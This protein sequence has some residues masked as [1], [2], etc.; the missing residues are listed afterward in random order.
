METTID[1]G[2]TVVF[3]RGSCLELIEIGEVL[4]WIGAACRASSFDDDYQY[5]TPSVLGSEANDVTTCRIS[6]KFANPES[7]WPEVESNT[8]CW[9]NI[10]RNPTIAKGYPVQRR[11]HSE[12]GLEI[13]I[14]IAASL[15]QAMYATTFMGMFLLKGFCS[16]FVPQISTGTSIVWHYLVNLNS[17]RL[18]YGEALRYQSQQTSIDISS[19]EGRRHFIGWS[20]EVHEL[21][22]Q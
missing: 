10:F 6:F 8:Q 2:R 13:P 9:R 3:A 12:M 1:D 22:G 15:G 7:L 5:C 16:A 20:S 21:I 19:L 14:D 18:S 17:D 11:D 4:A